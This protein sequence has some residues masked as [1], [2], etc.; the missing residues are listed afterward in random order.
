MCFHTGSGSIPLL[1]HV[2]SVGLPLC[3]QPLAQIHT[4]GLAFDILPAP[5]EMLASKNVSHG[6]VA[7]SAPIAHSATV[8]SPAAGPKAVVM[9]HS[10]LMSTKTPVRLRQGFAPRVVRTKTSVYCSPFS[11]P[12]HPPPPPTSPPHQIA[13][14]LRL[15]PCHLIPC[16]PPL[17]RHLSFSLF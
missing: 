17:A 12:P 11:T 9:Q 10:A 8:P 6:E 7:A 13:A 1:P 4:F 3:K 5:Q 16:V 15:T 14:T 2:I